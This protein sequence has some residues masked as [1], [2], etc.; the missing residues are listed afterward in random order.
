MYFQLIFFFNDAKDI[1]GKGVM[2]S[3]KWCCN[4]WIVID[5]HT[6]NLVLYLSIYKR[7]HKSKHVNT[8]NIKYGKIYFTTMYNRSKAK[9]IK[10]EENLSDFV[11]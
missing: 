9:I 4:K 6:Q 1:N 8:T 10:L 3:R 2:F 11:W 5:T 7:T